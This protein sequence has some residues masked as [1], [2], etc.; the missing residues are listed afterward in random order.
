[1]AGAIG[2][3]ITQ[4]RQRWHAEDLMLLEFVSDLFEEQ[5]GAAP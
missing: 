2:F 4:A 3:M 5:P 1:V